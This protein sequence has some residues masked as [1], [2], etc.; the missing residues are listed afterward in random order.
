[1]TVRLSAS[2]QLIFAL[3]LLALP[4]MG[5]SQN[6]PAPASTAAAVQGSNHVAPI[7]DSPNNANRM[8]STRATSAEDSA[9][10]GEYFFGLGVNALKKKD[11]AFAVHMYRVAASWAYKP[12]EYNL[13]VMYALG[14]GVPA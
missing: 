1:M 11:Y 4:A 3:S 6:N 14:Q 10:P 9:R 12:A 5:M 2:T 7:Y 13:A 8:T